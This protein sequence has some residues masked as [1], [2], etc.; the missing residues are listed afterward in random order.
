MAAPGQGRLLCHPQPVPSQPLL[1]RS[2]NSCDCRRS[3]GCTH[4]PPPNPPSRSPSPSSSLPPL[5]T[6]SCE[7][8]SIHSPAQTQG[9][10]C[11]IGVNKLELFLSPFSPLPARAHSSLP[12]PHLSPRDPLFNCFLPDLLCSS[13][14]SISLPDCIPLGGR[15][16]GTRCVPG[17][18]GLAGSLLFPTQWSSKWTDEPGASGGRAAE[19]GGE[20]LWRLDK[21]VCR[22]LG[23][24]L[25]PST[26][27]TSL[28]VLPG[29]PPQKNRG[30]REDGHELGWTWELGS[31]QA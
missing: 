5:S 2:T 21:P 18:R 6:S 10:G 24:T 16:A 13:L 12:I 14:P 30:G 31:L 28:S 11:F 26:P 9:P 22:V 27:K 20:P 23:V 3:P 1:V 7:A 8:S 19:S 15:E 4:T 25:V 17:W 29:P